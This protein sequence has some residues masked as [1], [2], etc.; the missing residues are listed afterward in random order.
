MERYKARLVAKGFTQQDGVDFLDS[1][2][3]VAK[4]TTVKGLLSL[5]AIRG[6]SLSRMDVTNAFLHGD[7]LEEVYMDFPPNYCHKQGTSLHLILCASFTSL[8]MDSNKL[9]DS[10][11]V[12]F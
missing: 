9:L 2:F 1:F 10:G 11:L 5:A 3:P 6:S 8:Y 12:S 7:L 4:L